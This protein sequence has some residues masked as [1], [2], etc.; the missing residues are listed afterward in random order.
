MIDFLHKNP[1]LYEHVFETSAAEVCEEIFEQHFQG[2][3]A[4]ILDIG[5]GTGRDLHRLSQRSP[6]CVGVDTVQ[7]MIDYANREYP[8]I[9]FQL[10]DMR[11][12][13]L[14][15]KFDV[16]MTLGSG[17]NYMLTNEDLECAMETFRVHSHAHSLLIIEPF[18]TASCIA[19]LSPPLRFDI[20]HQE[21]SAVGT[22]EYR[23]HPRR[24]VFERRR[25]WSFGEG[26]EDAYADGFNL[27]LLFS[28]E[29]KYFLDKNGFYVL[30]ILERKRSKIYPNS[31]YI[32][33]RPK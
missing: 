15:R 3:P 31:I 23:W 32:V 19:P 25:T 7:S 16:V 33:A 9:S 2:V 11:G 24:Q 29:L 22:A 1:H 20:S 30:D 8:G 4:S 26:R 5:C 10:G 21:V 14:D 17:L 6:D 18:N 27:R 12:I 28:Q 13:R